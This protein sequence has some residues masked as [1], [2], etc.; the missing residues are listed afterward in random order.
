MPLL[1]TF[2]FFSSLLPAVSLQLNCC[3]IAGGVEQFISDICPKKQV[4]ESFQVK[5]NFEATLWH[6]ALLLRQIPTRPSLGE[7]SS[8]PPR[9][10]F[11]QVAARQ[12]PDQR[13]NK[14]P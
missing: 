14:I 4:L 1:T 7:F 9:G 8:I 11:P 13:G 2:L 10:P 12:K 6:P 3:G 5:V